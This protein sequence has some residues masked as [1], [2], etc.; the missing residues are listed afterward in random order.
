MGTVYLARDP[1]HERQ[2][3]VKTIHPHLTTTQVRDRFEREIQITAQL[4]HPNILPLHDSGVAGDTL[5]YV[6][7]YVDGETLRARLERDGAL[8]EKETVQIGRDVA[9]ALDYAHRRGVVHRDIKPENILLTSDRAVVADFGISKAVEQTAETAL[10]RT[11]ALLGTPGYMPP[12]QFGGE[13]TGQTDIYAL[14]AAL[15]E[16]LT[17]HRWP[18]G[19]PVDEADWA[20]VPPEIRTALSRALEPAPGDRWESAVAFR[21]AIGSKPP[22]ARL[23]TAKVGL[24]LLPVLLVAALGVW[25]TLGPSASGTGVPRAGEGAATERAM[26]LVLPFE[27]LGPPEDV[28]FAAGMTDEITS[29]LGAVSGLGVIS[30][31]S[32]L[33]YAGTDKSTEDIGAELGVGYILGGSVRWEP[34]DSARVRITPELVRVSDDTQLWSE[35]YDRVIES[36]FDVQ[37]DIASRVVEHLGVA[38]LEAERSVLAA[39]PTEN[40]DAYALYLKGRY[41]WNKRTEADIQIALDYFEQAVELDPDYALAH[42]GIADIWI[43]RGWYSVLAPRETFPKAEQAVTRALEIDGTLA[44]AHASRAHIDLE[45]DYDWEAAN[46]G[47]E[48]AIELD[49]KYPKAHQWYGGFLSAMGRHDEALRQAEEARELDPLSLIINTWVGL[50]HYFAGRND[51]AIEEYLKALELDPDFAPAHWHLGWAF[52]QTGQYEKAI[53]EAQRAISL[54]GGSSLYTASLG[55]AYAKAGDHEA[56]RQVLQQL[57]EES[58]TRHVSAYHVAVIHGAL[59]ELDNAFL[60]LSRAYEERSPWIGYIKVDPRLDGLRSDPR[61]DSLL[62]MARLDS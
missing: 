45:F 7:P 52:G 58:A 46:R 50:R 42:A 35:S 12:E 24:A 20:D 5:Y 16:A 38:L 8:S 22:V 56:A 28:Y 2:V 14:A 61:F 29:R 59:G 37:S 48:R 47:Y 11:G 62:Q 27:N 32:A 54:S 33:R 3:A 60:W 1:K 13:V 40:L 57:E 17:G 31:K 25:Q 53:S 36:I 39:R 23:A 15:Y 51:V 10:T 34:G 6:M 26:V 18:L 21:D 44:E 49:P 19:K 30:R 41:F 43:F 9:S 55:H 4:Q